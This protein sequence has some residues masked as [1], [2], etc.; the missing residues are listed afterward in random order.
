M[1][2]KALHTLEFDKIIQKLEDLAASPMAKD[3]CRRLKP[4]SHL[5]NIKTWQQETADALSRILQSG[6]LSFSGLTDIRP[7]VMRLQVGGI[8][9][10][11]ELLD[12]SRCLDVTL[13][14]K[15]FF[16]KRSDE[17]EPDSLS[18]RFSFLEPMS[19]INNEIKRCILS[20]ELMAD[21]ASSGLK[22]VRRAIT[23]ANNKIKDQLSSMVN[24]A[25]G[26]GHL[27]N[28]IVTMRN[29]RYCLPVKQEHRGQIPG[30][31]HDQSSSGSTVFIE[32]MAVVKLNNELA[33]LALQEQKEIEKVLA[34][35]SNQIGEHVEELVYNLKTLIEGDFIF[36]KAELAKQMQASQPIFNEERRIRIKRGRHPL[37]DP[38]KVVPIDVHLGQDFNLLVI[39]GPNTGGKTV[40]LKTVGLLT[41]MGQAGLHIPAFDQSELGVFEE[42]FADIGD[43]QSIEQSLSTFSSH[44]VNTVHILEHADQHSLVLFDELGAGT[45]PTEGAALAM[46]ILSWLH[47]LDARVMATTHYSELKVF[48]LT[49]PGVCNASCE[50]SLETL[51]PT[52]RLLIGI[53]GKSNAFAIS[54]KLGLP[55][56][57]IQDAQTRIDTNEQKFEDVISELEDSRKT[58]EAE[59]AQIAAYRAEA[60]QLKK[61]LE[62]QKEK[63]AAGKER[64]M[65]EAKEEAAKVLQ[66]AKDYADETI[67]KFQK[68][69]MSGNARE[70]EQERNELRNRLKEHEQKNGLVSRSSNKKLSAGDLHIGD[71]VQV[72]SLG[73]RGT[74]STL[75]NAKGELFV[76]MGILRSQVS[77]TDLEL[78]DE[79]TV[80]GPSIQKSGSG[81]IKMSKSISI[82]PELNLI[83]KTTDEAVYLLDKYLDDAYLAH[84]PQV[85]IIHGRGTGALRNAVHA[86]LKRT[87]YVKSFRIGEFGEGDHGVTIVEFKD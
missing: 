50:F 68:W 79:P 25:A 70:M 16:Q 81:K 67:K 57:I 27:Q 10:M 17:L 26:K 61:E 33:E 82:H 36:A 14:V 83:G 51:Q 45:D 66:E 49:T 22:S 87:K 3:L 6:R 40:S 23:N 73:L 75:P 74:V 5:A 53:P 58:M 60:E 77:L 37:I 59:Q 84:L 38:K 18:E 72:L 8:L 64:I 35:L 56:H 55:D 39:T 30:M 47:A 62:Q 13:R 1:N 43:E 24:D 21:D 52:Y 41:L 54:S 20:P 29:G 9:G 46:S 42:V 44:M 28:N 2:E 19:P 65:S 63:L 15:S 32:P 69:G 80:S 71:A 34:D 12:V 76:Q 4:S 7:S 86:R 11:G 78:I 85:R 48:A 31:I